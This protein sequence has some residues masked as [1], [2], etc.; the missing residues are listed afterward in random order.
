MFSLV[1]ILLLTPPHAQAKSPDVN[2]YEQGADTEK[3][4]SFSAKVRVVREISDET[5][6]FFEGDKAKG[7]Y[8]LPHGGNHATMLKA[9]EASKKAN[10]PSVSVTADADKRIKS[11]EL[12]QQSEGYVP[13][14]DSKQAWD[15]EKAAASVQKK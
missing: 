14:A 11:V 8:T 3:T 12:K 4:Q 1:L 5:E 15:I 13:P 6:V 2:I 10:G 9:L 7:A